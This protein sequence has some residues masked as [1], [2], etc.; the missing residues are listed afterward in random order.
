MTETGFLDRE[1]YIS[2]AKGARETPPT[3]AMAEGRPDMTAV[4]T[5][6]RR[7]LPFIGGIK[8]GWLISY[9]GNQ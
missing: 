2:T 5:R 7:R 6:G 8:S 3:P 9:Q 1:F 4:F